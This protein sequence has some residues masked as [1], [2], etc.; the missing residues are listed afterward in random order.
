MSSQLCFFV[1]CRRISNNGLP[2]IFSMHRALKTELKVEN[3][4]GA[5]FGKAYCGVVG[6]VRRHEFAIMGA[7]VN[8]AARLM[9]SKVNKGILVDE[10]VRE[11]ADARYS[12][13]SL[14]PVEA[15]GYDRPV[16]ILEPIEASLNARKKKWSSLPFVGRKME[17]ETITDVAEVILTN[18]DEAQTSMIFLMGESGMGKS[19]LAV[20]AVDDIRKK[21][22]TEFDSCN[23]IVTARSTSTETQQRIPLR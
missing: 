16:P 21:N 20:S 12:F 19:A 17:R 5:T 9:A 14:P 13:N 10:A 6:G 11:Q 15:K 18:P 4:I 23:T 22:V 8:L 7:P 2:A 1:F 3:R